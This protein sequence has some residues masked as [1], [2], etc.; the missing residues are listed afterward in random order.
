MAGAENGEIA[1]AANQRRRLVPFRLV[2]AADAQI[3]KILVE[4]EAEWGF[5][6]AIRYGRLILAAMTAIGESPIFRARVRYPACVRFASP[7]AAIAAPPAADP[8][9]TSSSWPTV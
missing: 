3:G 4:S 9:V 1:R 6:A 5:E 8:S 2:G 7:A